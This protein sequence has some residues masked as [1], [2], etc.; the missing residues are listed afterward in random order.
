MFT[1]KRLHLTLNDTHANL[2]KKPHNNRCPNNRFIINKSGN[3]NRP[4][5]DILP[6]KNR[7]SV[8]VIYAVR[9]FQLKNGIGSHLFS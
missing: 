4:V 6:A 2:F 5:F 8:I 7:S 1:I 9:A 3:K